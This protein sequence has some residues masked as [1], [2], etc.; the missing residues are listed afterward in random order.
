MKL[1]ENGSQEAKSPTLSQINYTLTIVAIF[2]FV[3][4]FWITG[5]NL[6]LQTLY[7]LLIKDYEHRIKENKEIIELIKEDIS[8]QEEQTDL[9][10]DML[11]E[12]HEEQ[13]RIKK[14][15]ENLNKQELKT[16]IDEWFEE[17][18]QS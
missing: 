7:K 16:A 17:F 4:V 11:D 2:F 3:F 10:E 14:K 5:K 8:E 18:K 9:A 1:S 13:E 12:I 6:K 15:I